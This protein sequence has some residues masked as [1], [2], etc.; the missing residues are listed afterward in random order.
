MVA[1]KM[2]VCFVME[3]AFVVGCRF[4]IGYWAGLSLIRDSN[5]FRGFNKMNEVLGMPLDSRLRG[6]D[7]FG[8]YWIVVGT[9]GRSSSFIFM[10][11]PAVVPTESM[12]KLN[13]PEPSG[14]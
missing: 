2:V 13:P 1:M 12:I 6:N 8:R 3:I 11:L 4:G 5:L 10:V 14:S 7:I 9:Y